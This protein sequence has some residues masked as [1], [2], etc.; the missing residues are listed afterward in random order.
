MKQREEILDMLWVSVGQCVSVCV[1]EGQCGS[2]CVS[3]CQ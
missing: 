1:S 2:V 3:V